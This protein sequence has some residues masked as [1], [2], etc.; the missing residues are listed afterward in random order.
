MEQSQNHEEDAEAT[1]VYELYFLVQMLDHMAD[2]I[3][4]AIN[5]NPNKDAT[6]SSRFHALHQVL[7]ILEVKRLQAKGAISIQKMECLE[8]LPIHDHMA[9]TTSKVAEDLFLLITEKEKVSPVFGWIQRKTNK[10][11]QIHFI[12]VDPNKQI[13]NHLFL[14]N[15][16]L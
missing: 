3:C 9:S 16:Y 2:S 15:S 7:E 6:L 11:N 1:Y 13:T 4:M 10:L 14:H 8:T 5:S 12:Q